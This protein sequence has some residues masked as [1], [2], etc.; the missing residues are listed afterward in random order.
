M[1]PSQEVDIQVI[2]EDRGIPLVV[3]NYDT[4]ID[5]IKELKDLKKQNNAQSAL[6]ILSK[7]SESGRCPPPSWLVL[8]FPSFSPTFTLFNNQQ[9]G[10]IIW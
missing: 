2:K 1:L 7:Q 6:K 4:W 3:E 8:N 9:I 10:V 5:R